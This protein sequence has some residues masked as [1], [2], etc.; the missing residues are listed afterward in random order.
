MKT[1]LHAVGR[2]VL[3]SSALAC[4]TLACAGEAE[5]P[6]LPS[7]AQLS[8]EYDHP[9]AE[10]ESTRIRSVIDSV[11]EL[12]RLLAA[13]RSTATVLDRVTEAQEPASQRTGEGIRLRG[14]LR[15]TLRCPGDLEQPNYDEALNGSLVLTFGVQQSELLR[16]V[17]GVANA[18]RLSED[19]AGVSIGVTLDGPLDLDLGRNIPL[20]TSWSVPRWLVALRGS[21]QVEG[22]TFSDVSARVGPGTVE[23]LQRLGDGTSVV[24]SA[25][26]SAVSLRD[27]DA[28]WS[29]DTERGPCELE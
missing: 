8:L 5:L 16:S 7:L 24:L 27:A 15:V 22:V 10:L 6:E 23:T 26:S 1:N 4:S 20:G 3:A 25:S 14:S 19:V 9:T 29:C 21:L 11:P 17:G 18:C 28:T 13:F 2:L 12:Q